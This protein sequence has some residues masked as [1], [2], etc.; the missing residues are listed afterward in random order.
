MGRCDM[1][2]FAITAADGFDYQSL[3]ADVAK[4]IDG[5]R[6]DFVTHVIKDG[7]HFITVYRSRDI[8]LPPEYNMP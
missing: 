1:R 8:P 6:V 7:R 4:A 5:W 3:M 2:E